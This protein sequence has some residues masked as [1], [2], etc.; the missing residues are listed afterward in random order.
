MTHSIGDIQHKGLVYNTHTKM[1]V[2][3]KDQYM[4]LSIKDQNMTLSI[5]DTQHKGLV[6]D[7]IHR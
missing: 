5:D 1:T 3:M 2:S 6:F 4:S 7:T